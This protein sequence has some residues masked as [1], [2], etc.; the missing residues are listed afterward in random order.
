MAKALSLE[1]DDPTY[2][3]AERVR[4]RLK[5][6]SNLY[7]RKAVKHYDALYDRKLLE[8][9]YRAASQRLGAAHLEYLRETELLEDLP[10]LAEEPRFP[11]TG[12]CTSPT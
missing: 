4:R 12:G 5:L 11:S 3:D 6:P 9:E 7:I 2:R 10:E 8:E 1:L